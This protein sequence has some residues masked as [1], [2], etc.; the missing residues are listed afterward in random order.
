[1]TH[2][3]IYLAAFL[4]A[5][6][7]GCPRDVPPAH[8]DAA[9][10]H[11]DAEAMPTRPPPPGMTP[12]ARPSGNAPG[13]GEAQAPHAA[14]SPVPPQ[15][16]GPLALPG[17]TQPE[18]AEDAGGTRAPAG[19]PEAGEPARYRVRDNGVRCITFPCPSYDAIPEGG[20]E[21]VAIHEVDLAPAGLSEKRRAMADQALQGKGLEVT[22]RLKVVAKRGPAGDATVLEVQTVHW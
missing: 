1:M 2:R 17:P 3:S 10:S 12:P 5:S 20:G 16:G 14:P 18:G 9:A 21:A 4:A 22:G 15:M 11:E 6:L 13:V 19:V 8:R 7:P